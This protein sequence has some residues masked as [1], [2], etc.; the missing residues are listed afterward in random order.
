MIFIPYKADIE[1]NRIPFLTI[2]ISIAC[3]VIYYFQYTNETRVIESV[4]EYCE[5][6]VDQGFKFVLDKSAGYT[7]EGACIDLIYGIHR[8]TNSEVM[9]T[10][11]VD[12]ADHIEVFSEADGKQ[13]LRQLLQEKYNN[14]A[15][16]APADL[17]ANLMYEPTT[18]DP[19]T[20]LTSTFAHGSWDHVLGNIFF[21]F[22]F[23]ATLEII[24]G[25]LWYPLVILA[26]A[27]GTNVLYSLYAYVQTDPLPTLGL[28]GVVMGVMGMLVF[29]LPKV[30]IRFLFW[31]ILIVWRFGI[32]AWLV[33]L[34]YIGFDTYHLFTRDEMGP[35]NLVVH[36]TGATIGYGLGVLFFRD[37]RDEV[38]AEYIESH[39]EEKRKAYRRQRR[40]R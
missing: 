20:M 38:V 4:V 1:L 23:S 14:Y 28:S 39:P 35:I 16:Y 32:P 12:N 29:F 3:L 30:K 33:A 36:V 37:M 10:Q 27:F 24:L 6:A 15:Y 22:A 2:G 31:L 11:I 13:Y 26:L 25:F 5:S 40:R 19:F 34:W 7:G 21:F 8:S 9:L 18:W 17:S